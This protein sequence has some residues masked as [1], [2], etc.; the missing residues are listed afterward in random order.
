MPKLETHRD[1]E[2]LRLI[3]AEG[4]PAAVVFDS[5]HSGRAYPRDFKPQIP[6]EDLYG[7]EDR[8]VDTLIERAPAHGIALLTAQ[9][10]RAYIDPN[11]AEDDLEPEITGP[12]WT[13][14]TNPLYAAKGIGLI[15]RTSLADTPIYERPLDHADIERRIDRFWR[16]YHRALEAALLEAQQRWGAV[17]HVSWHSMRPIG[18]AL[19]SDPGEVRPD[20]VLSDRD[21]TSADPGFIELVDTELKRL[22][23][24]TARNWPFKG[25]YIT[26]LHG[27]PHAGRHSLQVEINRALYL[28]LETLEVIAEADR[29]RRALSGLSASIADYARSRAPVRTS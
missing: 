15:F 19:S 16:P 12:A 22:G 10:P 20:F 4:E 8:F 1:L 28:D 13:K 9:F 21:G 3:T 25:G 29:L 23:Y 11:R 17:W 5:P 7:Y 6:V 2:P 14:A 26:E 24:G 27:R 18:D